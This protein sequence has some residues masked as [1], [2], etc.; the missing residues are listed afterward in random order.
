MY[1]SINGA[2]DTIAEAESSKEDEI[3]MQTNPQQEDLMRKFIQVQ[4]E[5]DELQVEL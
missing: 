4:K 1:T 2:S 5:R 3:I